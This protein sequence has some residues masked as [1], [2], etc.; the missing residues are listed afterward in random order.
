MPISH[1]ALF[2]VALNLEDPWYITSMD[3][4]VEG[5]QLDIHVDFKSGSKF[6]CAKSRNQ[7]AA[8]TIQL[9]EL[10]VT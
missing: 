10:G 1:E 5:R 8:C 3:F 2:K 6:P 4:S 7:A 9:E